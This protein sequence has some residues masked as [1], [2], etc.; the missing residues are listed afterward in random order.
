M[1][2][3]LIAPPWVAV[4]PT[5]YGGTE[6]V[7]DILARGLQRAGHD[8]VLFTTGDSTCDVPRDSVLPAAIGVGNGGSATELRHVI[9]AYEAAVSA[10]VDIVHDHT[11]AGPVYAN[12]FVGLPV[13][14]TNHGPF[15]SELGDYY[16]AI[17]N[18]IP[19][20]AISHHQASTAT[21]IPL[22]AVIH[23]G[24]DPERS[25]AGKGD[26]GYAVFLGRMCRDKGIPTAIRVARRASIPLRIAAKMSEPAELLYFERHVEPLLGGLIQYIGEV[27]G[28]DKAV[29]LGEAMCLLNP[30]DWPEPFGMVMVEALAYGTPVVATPMGAAPEIVHHGRTGFVC[31]GED[32]LA[33]AVAASAD[34]DRDECRDAVADRFSA[35]RMVAD[36]VALYEKVIWGQTRLHVERG[37]KDRRRT[38]I[39]SL[40]TSS[41]V[42]SDIRHPPALPRRLPL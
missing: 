8:V 20:I 26:G 36:H 32:D 12:R 2:I 41:P 40:V 10:H 38:A 37:R 11:L 9:H 5:A 4:P 15:Q 27:G 22:A 16:R 28:A 30:I 23:H 42:I 14:T 29:L 18:T 17:S 19:I 3:M 6:T 7:L 24:I 21:D 25:P 33:L 1:R 31:F 34:L 35:D 13:V 39:A